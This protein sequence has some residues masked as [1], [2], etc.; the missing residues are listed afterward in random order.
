LTEASVL[1]VEALA[2]RGERAL[3][4]TRAADFVAAHPDSPQ[5][6]RLRALIPHKKAR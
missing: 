4:A 2:A 6:D 1:E 3:A 5:A